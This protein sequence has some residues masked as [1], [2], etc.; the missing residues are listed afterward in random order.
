MHPDEEMLA[1][2][3]LGEDVPADDVAHTLGCPHCAGV[4]DELR[5]TLAQARDGSHEALVAP[6]DTVWQAIAAEVTGGDRGTVPPTGSATTTPADELARRRRPSLTW[7]AVAAA[8]VAGVLLGTFGTR[9]LP[10]PTVPAP[11]VL[12]RAD[13]DTLDTR[14]RG[15]EVELLAG[16]DPSLDLRI[17]VTPLDPGSGYLEVWLINTDLKRMVSIGVLP[18]GSSGQDFT[19]PRA[20]IEQ[21]YVIV[22]I[23]H[24]QFDDRPQHSGDSLLRGSLS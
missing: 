1:A 18:N 8:V 19:V 21:G 5:T 11:Q 13:L 17:R 16:Q 2:I 15:G 10:Q 23:S 12:A 6:P 20:L 9:L 22:D 4:L 24:E 14:T 7:L 3:A